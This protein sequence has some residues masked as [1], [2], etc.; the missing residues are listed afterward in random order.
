MDDLPNTLPKACVVNFLLVKNERQ[1]FELVDEKVDFKNDFSHL[2]SPFENYKEVI[3]EYMLKTQGDTNALKAQ[4]SHL[5]SRLHHLKTFS[6][7]KMR[8][9]NHLAYK[10]GKAMINGSKSGGGGG[11]ILLPFVLFSIKILHKQEVKYN[12][13]LPP[14]ESYPDYEEGLREKQCFTYK[15]GQALMDAHKK[16][17]LG[18]YIKFYFF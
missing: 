10:L 14:L 8:V 18:G 2:I 6:S 13:V 15:L 11:G 12:A 1:F 5:E 4:I 7:A 17:Y 9:Q 3:E 16:W